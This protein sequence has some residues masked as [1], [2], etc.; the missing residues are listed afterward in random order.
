MLAAAAGAGT[1]PD[2]LIVRGIRAK[3]GRVSG[4]APRDGVCH[5]NGVAPDD[6]RIDRNSFGGM[7]RGD[8][9]KTGYKQ[10][11]DDSD[12]PARHNEFLMMDLVK[13]ATMIGVMLPLDL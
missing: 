1:R 2:Q 7:G 9:Y 5:I 13:R 4:S 11:E 8:E 3:L 10:D 6:L 12:Q